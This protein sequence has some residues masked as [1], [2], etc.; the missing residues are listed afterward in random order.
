MNNKGQTTLI[1][2]LVAVVI[3]AGIIIA[4][5]VTGNTVK[6]SDKNCRD[7]ETPYE[8]VETYIDQ[9]PYQEVE[10]YNDY[11]D[12]DSTYAVNQEKIELFGRGYYQQAQIGIKNLDTGGGWV[13][14][15]VNWETLNRKET[16]KIRHYINPDETIEFISEF[17]VDSGEDNKFTYTYVSDPIQKQRL[18]TKYRDV[19]KTRTVTKYKTENICD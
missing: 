16:D 17:D 7:V 9:E 11:L 5:N 10:Y 12:L 4:V 13:T 18:V 6:D 15:T 14:V 2:I 8:E 1:I 3:V 19:E